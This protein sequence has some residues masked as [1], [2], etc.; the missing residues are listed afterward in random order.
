MA[1]TNKKTVKTPKNPQTQEARITA[2]GRVIADHPSNHITPA[3]MRGL[4][5]DAEN[6]DIT[7]QHELFAD[8]EER[9]SAIAAALSTRKMA[10]LGL[11]WHIVAP[12]QASK[13]EEDLAQAVQDYLDTLPAFDDVLLDLMDAVGH[14]F[15]ALE[16]NWELSGS[17]KTPHAFKH[18]PQSWFKWDKDDN[19]LLKTPDNPMGEP[20]WQWGWIVHQHKTRS[21]QA[22]RNGLFRTL[23]W[24]YMFKHYSV[25][26]FAEFL[27]LYGMPIRIG[28]YGAGATEKAK[29]T[30]LRAVAEIGHNAAGIMPEG[31]MIELHQAANGTTA[32]TNPFMT[33]VEWCEKSATRL[34]LG[35]TLTSGA[36]GKASTNALG[37]I[38]NE[39]RRDLLISDAKRLA[40][41][42]NQQLIEPFL[43]V[44]FAFG[45]DVR[46]PVFE[47][48]TRETADLATVAEALPKLVDIG[49]QIPEKWVHEKLAIPEIVDGE[50]VLS[51]EQKQPAQD[52]PLKATLAALSVQKRA[53]NGVPFYTQ[54]EDLDK[55]ASEKAVSREQQI[56]EQIQDEAFRQ[57]DFNAQLNPIVKQAV[58]AM[59]AC[60][61]YEEADAA[62]TALYPN[63]D[64]QAL[65][66]YMQQALFLSDLLGQANAKH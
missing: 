45:E 33:M 2:N 28:K 5:D 25:H 27:E 21:G 19:L 8:I 47:F 15:A 11:D 34:I 58:A 60:D 3:K 31:M 10:L 64:N 13:Q 18:K 61:S 49:V 62:L 63:L 59:M 4:F 6:G 43:R 51:R 7:A 56:L 35:Q 22:A 65:T 29:Q 36:D 41:T 23:A 66:R 57:P 14:G 55:T 26:D 46:L 24:L 50:R 20:L 44:N 1:K 52:N 54:A 39:V 53:P 48:D 17:L 37:K 9:D 12:R 30:L 32:A 16:I 38:H 42:I 40:Q